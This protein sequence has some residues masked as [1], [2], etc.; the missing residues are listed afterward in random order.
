MK[1][2][3]IIKI[4]SKEMNVNEFRKKY[5]SLGKQKSKYEK[6]LEAYS[7][8]FLEKNYNTSLTVPIK[9][10]GRLTSTGGYFKGR[11][12]GGVREPMEIQISERFIASALHDGQEGLEA[13]LD[14]LKHELVHYVLF[15]TGKEFNDGDDEFENELARLDI[16]ASGATNKKLVQSKKK[17]VWYKVVDIYERESYDIIENKVKT[18]KTYRKHAQKPARSRIGYERIGYEVVKSYF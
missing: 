7:N 11:I 13:I 2:Q 15:K 12:S 16:G 10:S 1:E 3:T 9:I 17:N 8:E 4:D 5:V 14:T 6:D 18:F